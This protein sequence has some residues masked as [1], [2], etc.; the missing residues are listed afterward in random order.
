MCLPGFTARAET[1]APGDPGQ[2][3]TGGEAGKPSLWGA[4]SRRELWGRGVR[5][6]GLYPFPSVSCLGKALPG[7]WGLLVLVGAESMLKLRLLGFPSNVLG[8]GD[9]VSS[10]HAT[11]S[12]MS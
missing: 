4:Q 12:P 9:N 5:D 1:A 2:A 11:L 8:R 10:L 7:P 3:V 6:V